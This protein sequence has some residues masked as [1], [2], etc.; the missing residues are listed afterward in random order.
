[1]LGEHDPT[2]LADH[3]Q[4]DTILLIPCEMVVVDLDNQT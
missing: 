1:M 4:P 3:L 2:P